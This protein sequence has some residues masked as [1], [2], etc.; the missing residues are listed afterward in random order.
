MITQLV[1]RS[2][3]GKEVEKEDLYVRLVSALHTPV[4]DEEKLEDARMRKALFEMVYGEEKKKG[5]DEKKESTFFSCGRL[6][7]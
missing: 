1:T 4:T 5:K 6:N 2:R 7:I 3:D